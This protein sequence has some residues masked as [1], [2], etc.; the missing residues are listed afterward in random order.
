MI[1]RGGA[2]RRD[3]QLAIEY[4]AGRDFRFNAVAPGMSGDTPM[5]RMIRKEFLRTFYRRLGKDCERRE[6]H[7]RRRGLTARTRPGTRGRVLRHVDGGI[8]RWP[9]VSGGNKTVIT[10]GGDDR[11][12]QRNTLP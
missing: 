2:E 5:Q 6:R 3:Q 11:G 12:D 1:T 4:G 9:L 8:A 7:H 10:R